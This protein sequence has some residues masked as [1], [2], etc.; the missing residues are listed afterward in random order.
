[1]DKGTQ[2]DATQLDTTQQANSTPKRRNHKLG[3]AKKN[4]ADEFYTQY[5]DVAAELAHYAAELRG[6]VVYCNC[7]DPAHSS[8]W[9]YLSSHF[10]ELELKRL[11]STYKAQDGSPSRLTMIT[12]DDGDDEDSA[13]TM[14][15]TSQALQ[16]DGDFASEECIAILQD[17]DIVITNPPFS[18]FRDFFSVLLDNDKDFLVLG[19]M[20]AT[21]YKVVFDHIKSEKVRFGVTHNSGGMW[22]KV[23][24]K[25]V[26]NDENN[27]RFD[28]DGNRLAEVSNSRWLTTLQSD[29]PKPGISLQATYVGNEEIGRAHV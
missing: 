4:K 20:N 24:K 18:L 16:G 21:S 29:T 3:V 6:K 26:F 5:D 10:V 15:R 14:I 13:P 25:F 8:F 1:M 2:T 11:I 22:F 7:D 28:K 19:N 17:A 9:A 12:R 23:P 27:C